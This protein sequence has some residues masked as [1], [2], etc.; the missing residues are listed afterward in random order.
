MSLEEF[1]IIAPLSCKILHVVHF[2]FD[3]Y[4]MIL[5]ISVSNCVM[6]TVQSNRACIYNM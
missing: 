5:I 3:I 1:I 4:S 2:K 6:E